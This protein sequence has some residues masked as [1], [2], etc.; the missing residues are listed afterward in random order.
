MDFKPTENLEIGGART[1]QFGGEGSVSPGTFL[2]WLEDTSFAKLGGGW[3]A[4]PT[5]KTSRPRSI[6]AIGCP[7]FGMPKLY[8]EWG[9]EDTGSNRR[10]G[11]FY[12]RSVGYI[13][14][15]YIPRLTP[16]GRTDLRLEYADNVNEGGPGS[17]I[18]DLWYSHWNY[19]RG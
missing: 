18:N 10:L 6:S 14:G 3:A 7:G 2:E 8:G 5:L 13:L 19:T 15:M 9:G 1:F 11:N 4:P 16:D 12:S 17:K